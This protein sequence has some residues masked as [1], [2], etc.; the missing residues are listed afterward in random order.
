VKLKRRNTGEPAQFVSGWKD[1]ARYLGKG[2]RTVQRYEREFGLPVRRP[3]GKPCGSVVATKAE[4][5]AWVNAS[6]I[7]QAYRLSPRPIDVSIAPFEQIRRGMDEMMHLRDQ[8]ALLR[9]EVRGS[10][11]LLR[12]SVASLEHQVSRT[13][14][15]VHSDPTLMA[16][17]GY[18]IEALVTDSLNPLK[19]KR[20]S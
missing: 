18:S 17:D 20:A 11:E 4:I 14:G 8:M 13:W 7:R 12:E 10:V 3:A 19:R 2:V 1:I 6:P 16:S 9:S 15:G 5:D